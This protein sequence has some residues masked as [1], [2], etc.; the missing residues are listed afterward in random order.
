MDILKKTTSESVISALKYQ[1]ARHGIPDVLITD[2]GPQFTSEKFRNFVEEWQFQHTTSSPGYPQSNG[3]AEN[4]VKTVRSLM[5]KSLRAG[6]D[7][8]LALLA[9]GNTPTEGVG[10][11]PAHRRF[12]RRTKTL[13]PTTTALLQPAVISGQMQKIQKTKE[14]Q[15]AAYKR[16]AKPL[17][18]LSLDETVRVQPIKTESRKWEKA[19]VSRTLPIRLYEVVTADG[20]TYRRN[21]RHLRASAESSELPLANAEASPSS[22]KR[23]EERLQTARSS[24][25]ETPTVPRRSGRV[26]RKAGYLE[27]YIH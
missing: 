23:A 7:P 4:A 5:R 10:T 26:V 16:A 24:S 12:S 9:F 14:K 13:L 3:K 8:F 1:F 2:N 19:T 15:A 17:Q 21:R 6:T 18:P 25:Q 22:H 20:R 27:D 11:S